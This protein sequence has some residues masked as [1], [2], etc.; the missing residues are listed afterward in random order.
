VSSLY[1]H[2][3]RDASD[4]DLDSY[5]PHVTEVIAILATGAPYDVPGTAYRIAYEA[6]SE[7]LISDWAHLMSDGYIRPDEDPAPVGSLSA[8][9]T[10]YFHDWRAGWMRGL[11]V[12]LT[13]YLGRVYDLAV[14]MVESDRALEAQ[15]Y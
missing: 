15:G 12:L 10:E 14:A 7:I 6:A 11:T 8:C 9:L 5:L 1:D 4:V 2:G 13:E 3:F